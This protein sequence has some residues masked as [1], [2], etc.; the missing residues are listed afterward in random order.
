M[1]GTILYGRPEKLSENGF[2]RRTSF[3]YFARVLKGTSAPMIPS[4]RMMPSTDPEQSD[5]DIGRDRLQL[6]PPKAAPVT[7]PN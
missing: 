6:G 3:M 1:H 4:L 7:E 5:Y 2:S